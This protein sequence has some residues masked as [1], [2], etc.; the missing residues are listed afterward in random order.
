VDSTNNRVGIGTSSPSEKLEVSGNIFVNTIG[1]PSMIVKTSG[2]GNNPNYRLQAD[3]NYWDLQGTF[4]NANDELFFMYNGS[5]KMG[6]DSIGNVIVGGT[7]AVNSNASTGNI[8]I[9]GS[10]NAIL[11]FTVGGAAKGWFY[12]D[13]TNFEM[14]NNVSGANKF[15][16]NGSERMRIDSSGNL[17]VG[18][19]STGG[20]KCVIENT[21]AN[22]L[23]L[24]NKD[25]GAASQYACYFLRNNSIVGSIQT[26][27]TAT[28]YVTSSDYRLKEDWQ[29]MTGASDRVLALN[30]VNFA[31]KSDGSR[32]DGFLAHEAQEIVPEAVSGEKDAMRDEQ[33]EV[34]P[35]VYEDVIIPAV[36]DDDGNEIE[37]ERTEQRLVSEAVIG[38]RQVPDY[39]GIDQSKLVPLL[40]AAL[41]E[42][43]TEIADLKARVTALEAN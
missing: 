17:L 37:P 22:Q 30:P 23:V 34:T 12:H 27:N 29:P 13:G 21:S 39:Q 8:T 2:A 24:S 19:A 40:T 20:G 33:Y 35:A 31:W 42:A 38:T 9:N 1:N 10:G 6:I 16:T 15:Y 3:T 28:S 41:K 26:T 18:T 4:S 5:V 25:T 36:L 11:N 43:L 32:V 14:Y 7:T